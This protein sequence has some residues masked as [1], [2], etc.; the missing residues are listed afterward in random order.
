MYNKNKAL[1]LKKM[2]FELNTN[3]TPQDRDVDTE[4]SNEILEA[5][6][7]SLDAPLE[8]R[9]KRMSDA[10]LKIKKYFSESGAVFF[11]NMSNLYGSYV[12]ENLIVRRDHPE[13]LIRSVI[14][15]SDINV[16]LKNYANCAIWTPESWN[17]S[18]GIAFL[19]GRA[20]LNGVVSVLAF[21]KGEDIEVMDDVI[22]DHGP[23]LTN[24]GR[25]LVRRMGGK[26]HKEDLRFSV[27]G[28]P[29]HMFP[30]EHMTEDELDRWYE[31]KDSEEILKRNFRVLRGFDFRSGS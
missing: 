5:L 25:H 30:E 18:L 26:V 6:S 1:I 13:K 3:K 28:F 10:Y 7:F 2:N 29:V 21:K 31:I 22:V 17:N 23:V 15:G 27:L 16:E 12:H 4:K 14:E 24:P 8:E 11:D 9:R 20:M 19:E